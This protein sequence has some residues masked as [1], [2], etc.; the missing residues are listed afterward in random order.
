[1]NK[2]YSACFTLLIL[3]SYKKNGCMTCNKIDDPCVAKG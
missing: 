1:M 2:F 3:S